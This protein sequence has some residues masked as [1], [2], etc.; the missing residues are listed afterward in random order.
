[1]QEV[2][3]RAFTHVSEFR[4]EASPL[5]WLMKIATHHCLNELRSERAGVARLVRRA[6]SRRAREAHDGAGDGD[7]GPG[8]AAAVPVG[9]GDAG[10]RHPLPR[11]RDDA[12]GGGG[13]AGPLGA[14]DPQAAGGVR[15]PGRRGSCHEREPRRGAD[16]APAV[17]GRGG[18][19]GGGGAA[20]PPGWTAS[21]A[22][23]VSSAS[24]ASRSAFERELPFARFRRG[25]SARAE[26]RAPER[27]ARRWASPA[28][29][30]LA[31]TVVVV[32]L[33]GRARLAEPG[34]GNRLKGGADVELRIAGRD[35]AQRIAAAGAPERLQAGER[36]RIGYPAARWATWPASPWTSGAR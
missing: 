33:A 7:A 25:W 1:M 36:V 31:A 8:A 23:R 30:A 11:G 14:H 3:A 16:A 6:G 9:R 32:A 21:A 35:G 26:Q 17:R 24:A 19:P 34:G 29:A 18:G 27:P 5:T 28:L 2:F 10:G 12:G 13:G 4:A 15:A 22:P 20:R